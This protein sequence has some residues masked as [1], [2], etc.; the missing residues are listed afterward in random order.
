MHYVNYPHTYNIF[1]LAHCC[2]RDDLVMV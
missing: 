2:A 1:L